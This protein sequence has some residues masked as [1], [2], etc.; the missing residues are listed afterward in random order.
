MK[1]VK[2]FTVGQLR[3]II[4]DLPNE[5]EL[6]FQIMPENGIAW[7][8]FAEFCKD[9]ISMDGNLSCIT[10]SHPNLKPISEII[11]NISPKE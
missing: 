2:V 11:E 6:I 1:N 5:H 10:L 9:I 3:E 4:K 8:C 7:N